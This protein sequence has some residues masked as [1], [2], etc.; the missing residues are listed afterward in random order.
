[1]SS[2]TLT[3][4][5]NVPGTLTFWVIGLLAWQPIRDVFID[6]PQRTVLL[7]R[8]WW[9]TVLL[10][11]G[12]AIFRAFRIH[13]AFLPPLTAVALGLTIRNMAKADIAAA[14]ASGEVASNAD[15]PWLRYALLSAQDAL[16][17]V[18]RIKSPALALFGFSAIALV[19]IGL[20]LIIA[21]ILTFEVQGIFESLVPPAAILA[22]STALS[23]G[24]GGSS[25]SRR[26]AIA[27]VLAAGAHV[28]ADADR[29]RRRRTRWLNGRGP[30]GLR[31]VA[32]MVAFMIILVGLSTVL[33]SQLGQGPLTRRVD[34]RSGVSKVRQLESPTIS[35][36]KRLVDLA[37]T[38]M[39][40]VDARDESG[41]PVRAYWRQAALDRFDGTTWSQ[42][43]RRYAR[44]DEGDEVPNDQPSSVG[45]I[46]VRQTV[47]ID[48]LVDSWLP[49]AF[50]P[51]RLVKA[52]RG[53]RVSVDPTTASLIVSSNTTR[54]LTYQIDSVVPAVPASAAP[55]RVD[56]L[57]EQ[58]TTVPDSVSQEVRD[59]AFEIVAPEPDDVIAQARLLENFFLENFTYSTDKT[60]SG[61]NPLDTFILN[62]RT[63]YCEQ[64][65]GSFAAMARSVGIPARVAVGFTTGTSQAD[66]S[67]VITGENAHAWP[68]ILVAEAGWVPFEPTPGRGLLA[69]DLTPSELPPTTTLAPLAPTSTMAAAERVVDPVKPNAGKR[70]WMGVLFLAIVLVTALPVVWLFRPAQI[71]RRRIERH[72]RLLLDGVPIDRRELEWAWSQ[73]VK[74]LGECQPLPH[75]QTSVNTPRDVCRWASLFL[76]PAKQRC[77]EAIA[78]VVT[79]SR[80]APPGTVDGPTIANATEKAQGL[81]E[82]LSNDALRAA[83]EQMMPADVS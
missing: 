6:S 60:W 40:H 55:R 5:V 45:A 83:Q 57:T 58:M 66:G 29:K 12:G 22:V 9:F 26:W 49:A 34:W 32:A 46:A 44:L 1:M 47:T 41:L 62:D 3:E 19:L 61:A 4:R 28:I 13:W 23:L 70:L 33:S 52:P 14:V 76:A 27:F 35:L 36:R 43:A 50:Q 17:D 31:A 72:R 11:A 82:S 78:S 42:S 38:P 68:E 25:S 51:T 15:Q 18:D 56:D 53:A 81:E 74:R 73:L 75:P 79:A 48:G 80:F 63:G 39:F 67:F 2:P 21:H 8:L 24:Q 20:L 7:N 10:A 59:L 77:L 16:A 71:Q 54:T 64:F 30:K 65:A 37:T 69:G